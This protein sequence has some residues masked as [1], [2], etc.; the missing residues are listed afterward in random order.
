MI[1]AA[2]RFLVRR[3]PLAALCLWAFAGWAAE[4]S[5]RESRA[6]AETELAL[7]AGASAVEAAFSARA[8]APLSL[9]G[10][11]VFA[12]SGAPPPA[13]GAVP[14]DQILG[15]GDEVTV[16][17][18]GSKPLQGRY[19]VNSDGHLLLPDLPPITAAGRSLADLRRELQAAYNAN[20]VAPQV[21]VYLS[22]ARRIAVLVLGLAT[23]PG[24]V[25]TSAFATVFDALLAA[26]GVRKDGSLRDIKLVR[27]GQTT[28]VDLYQL[29]LR[30]DGG[31]GTL[32]LRD[33]DRLMIP[34]L[35]PTAALAGSVKRP[36][37]YEL[38]PAASTVTAPAV[39]LPVITLQE[40]IALGGGPLRPAE[41][42]ALRL[43]IGADGRERA[44]TLPP[45]ADPPLRDGDAVILTPLR[46]ERRGLVHLEGRA[47]RPGPRAMDEA[48][49]LAGLAATHE[50]P[51]DA[52][53]PFAALAS[54]AADGGAFALSAVDL[55]ELRQK[56]GDRALRDG[57][58]L[59]VLGPAE[60]DYLT[61]SAVLGLLRG[62][63]KAPTPAGAPADGEDAGAC[64]ALEALARALAAD[65][66][67]PLADGP[68]ARLAATLTGADLPCPDLYRRHPDLLA[69]TL[70]HA[71]LRR[72][73]DGRPGFY[74]YADKRERG[75]GSVADLLGPR[76]T[77]IGHV[78][79][80]G[81]RSLADAPS[82]R[83]LLDGGKGMEP[84]AYPLIGVVER[85]GER[86]KARRL[87]AFSPA[88]AAAGRADL[89]LAD[90][91]R[92]HVF[93][94]ARIR[95][96]LNPAPDPGGKDRPAVEALADGH[97]VEP[98]DA[99]MR[100]FL[101]ERTVQVRGAV[102]SPA[103]LPVADKATVRELIDAAGGLTPQAETDAIEIT[104]PDAL[105]ARRVVSLTA[106][107]AEKLTLGPGAALRIN[108]RPTAAETGAVLVEGEVR[109]PGWY[110]VLRGERLSSV[111]VRAGGLTDEAYP[112]G[113]V[114]LRESA[115]RREK[116]ALEA[117][118]RSLERNIALLLQKGE[119]VRAEDVGL[120]RQLAGQLRGVEPPGRIVA[121]ADPA[122]LAR[123]PE[124]DALLE[125]GDRIAVPKRPLTVAVTGEVAAP[126]SYPFRSGK[127]AEDYL[128]DAGG[129]TGV[130]DESRVFMVLPDGRAEPL[131]VSAWNHR[132]A[133]V[134]PG[135][136]LVV[137]AD[138]RPYGARELVQSVAD[139][140]AKIALTAA[141]ISVISR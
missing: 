35:G 97:A 21:F 121:E 28:P 6:S 140:L 79:H 134:P 105:P 86:D 119:Q 128:R 34:P 94:A 7:P 130:A 11:D 46:E 120:I 36:G 112:A 126:G 127:D 61:S 38:P 4:P 132:F 72:G 13:Q 39:T 90:R 60:V 22:E 137:P 102:L 84:G 110:D 74:P 44:E 53:R 122:A 81:V 17:V 3:A 80:P 75:A 71:V 63:S 57:E 85:F 51:H 108:P 45:G 99:A 23:R 26:G 43:T 56:R 19:Q 59:M 82:L 101:A 66:H 5:R 114:F 58:R 100:A 95:A 32:K 136:T 78:R 125:A 27:Q 109:R 62:D 88:A 48:R 15:V 111:L 18:R 50:L 139:V 96:M 93:S 67:G 31:G 116:E 131:A 40:L 25:E 89:K 1:A 41:H 42:R 14:G 107:E 133:A 8:G 52:W 115:K 69:F 83:V 113:T 49:T 55:N 141:S 129:L 12:A 47:L 54:P 73:G 37:V 92:V 91:D 10:Y 30:G 87:I 98:P 103:G 77:L 68:Q 117:Q 70:S 104:R 138:P 16:T 64:P 33:G 124:R 123:H 2:R 76:T 118:A 29:L 65:P 106:A 20:Q 24:R 135:A 9:F